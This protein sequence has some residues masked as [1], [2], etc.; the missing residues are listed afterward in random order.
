M[1]HCLVLG[2]TPGPSHKH[3]LTLFRGHRGIGSPAAGVSLVTDEGVVVTFPQWQ[4]L[5]PP[6]SPLPGTA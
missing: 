1:N 2:F 4:L 3:A 5:S 6:C